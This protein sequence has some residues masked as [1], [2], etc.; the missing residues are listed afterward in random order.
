L[1]VDFAISTPAQPREIV[2]GDFNRNGW[3]DPARWWY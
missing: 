1:A 2:H 3:L